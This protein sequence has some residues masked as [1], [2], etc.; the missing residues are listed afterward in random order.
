MDHE[1]VI[2]ILGIAYVAIASIVIYYNGGFSGF[3]VFGGFG[4]DNPTSLTKINEK[5]PSDNITSTKID[6]ISSGNLDSLTK[7][8]EK[9]PSDNITSI[10]DDVSKVEGAG[11]VEGVNDII[12]SIF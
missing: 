7:I 9:I 10:I 6:D 3:G 2:T 12:N 11:L 4:G 5:I 1:D 8:N